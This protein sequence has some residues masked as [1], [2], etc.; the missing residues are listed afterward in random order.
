MAEE[1]LEG[2]AAAPI[3]GRQVR[4][5]SAPNYGADPGGVN[6]PIFF[7][8]TDRF[9]AG[10]HRVQC[11]DVQHRRPRRPRFFVQRVGLQASIAQL[12]CQHA[13]RNAF[14]HQAFNLYA[15]GSWPTDCQA[16][17][18][19][20]DCVEHRRARRDDGPGHYLIA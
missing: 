7:E 6:T 19:C 15:K 12:R 3:Y 5:G 4:S 17:G 20:V 18:T 2:T 14:R 1:Y 13:A 10:R 9:L 8:P 16:A 11:A